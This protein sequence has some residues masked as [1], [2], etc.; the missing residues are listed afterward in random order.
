[1]LLQYYPVVSRISLTEQSNSVAEER[2][3]LWLMV[4]RAEGGTSRQSGQMELMIH[5]RLFN[6]DAFGVGEALN[7]T[8]FGEGLV[9]R[10]K[11]SLVPC[12][13]TEEACDLQSRLQAERI[14]MK[15]V[16]LL[17]S[18]CNVSSLR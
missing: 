4:D 13:D 6:D 1:M 17:G 10:G 18:H 16:I 14:L 5:R 8:A 12:L 11:H 9:V 2:R 15:P 3:Q 7:E